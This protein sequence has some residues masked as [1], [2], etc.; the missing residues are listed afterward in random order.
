MHMS[1][2]LIDRTARIDRLADGQDARE[3]AMTEAMPQRQLGRAGPW[4]SAIG[5]GCM[6]MSDVYAH[7]DEDAGE[8]TIHAALEA[9]VTFLN[10]GDFYG[11]GRNELLLSRA[12]KGRRD[13]AFISVKTG[14][15]KSPSGDYTGFDLRPV[16][17]RNNLAHTLT[18]L[19]TDYVDLYQPSRI[20]PAVPIEDTIGAIA[21][22]VKEG[23]VRHI[24]LSEMG[25]VSIRRAHA[26]HPICAHEVEYSLLG[27]DIEDEI[28]PV[29]R[30]LGIATVAYSVLAGG[31]LGGRYVPGKT[32][33]SARDHMPRFQAEAIAANLAL[34][35]RLR[36]I[37]NRKSVSVA[38]LAIA[39]VLSRGA[40][41]VPLAGVR[42]PERLDDALAAARLELTAADLA[43]V[44]QIAPRGAGQGKQYG[45]FVQEMLDR[46]RA[47]AE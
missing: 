28:L 36:A 12:L 43:E 42:R 40:D 3:S 18:R 30:E 23:W 37:T 15:L 44:E 45:G 22:L 32:E 21:D 17:I 39:W 47:R 35:E 2:E 38:S 4:V 8:R 1:K 33:A 46:E 13:K 5:L 25:A 19:G 7:P 9:G 24:G 11:N 41:V 16:A 6:A 34:V 27:R 31:I 10:T 14:A 26:V 29:C 20:D